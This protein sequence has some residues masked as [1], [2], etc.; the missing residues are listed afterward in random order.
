MTTP[1]PHPAFVFSVRMLVFRLRKCACVHVTY[2]RLCSCCVRARMFILRTCACV[3]V[4]YAPLGSCCV[5]H[6]NDR[7]KH[8]F[9]NPRTEYGIGTVFRRKPTHFEIF[10]GWGMWE[11]GSGPPFY[12]V[13]CQCPL[14]NGSLQV[15][16]FLKLFSLFKIL[17]I[18]LQRQNSL[19]KSSIP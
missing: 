13:M 15:G 17:I 10:E 3:R 6:P 14:R 7:R 4:A 18:H 16:C 2:A 9:R 12:G 19:R 8:H 1:S 11:S 5:H